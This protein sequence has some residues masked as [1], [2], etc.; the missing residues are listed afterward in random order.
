MEAK[1][2]PLSEGVELICVRSEKFKTGI[3]SVSLAAP[4]TREHATANALAGDVL[5][6]GS[7]AYPDIAAISLACDELY[8][9]SVGPSVRQRGESQSLCFSASFL[10]D[11][12]AL[13]GTA[14]LE[15]ALGLVSELLLHPL[16][17]GGV[18][19]EDYVKSEG[20]N[21]A[22]QIRARVNDKRGWAMFR[23]LQEMCAGEA[24]ALDKL[25]DE[26]EAE[27]MDAGVLWTRYQ[28]LVRTA[29]VVFYYGGAAAPERV[30]EAVRRYFAP[31]LTQRSVALP[32]EVKE[33]AGA[34]RR[35]RDHMD[36]TQGKLAMG[37]RTG[38]VTMN[39]PDY[40]ALLVCNALYGATSTSR[41]FMEVRERRSLCYYA[42]SAIDRFKG[43]MAVSSGVEFSKFDEAEGEILRQLEEI[44]KGAFTQQELAAA[45]RAVSAGL[46][47]GLDSQGRLEDHWTAYALGG[48]GL[49]SPEALIAPVEAVTARD[50]CRAAEGITLDTVYQLC[51]EGE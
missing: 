26:R 16:T 27:E 48:G 1:C 45:R 32:C 36:V 23:L 8:G 17:Q 38:G 28:A 22:D 30:E 37:F 40:P 5:Y 34:V 18:F 31:L 14:V 13:D 9:A 24:Y 11:R 42:S 19:R 43:I 33:R 6:R 47:A 21:L 51:G 41:L 12:Y 20:A 7:A 10:D 3:F 50:V 39:H 49:V 25:G 29:R 4:L 2:M 46:R 35:V 44:K 15:P